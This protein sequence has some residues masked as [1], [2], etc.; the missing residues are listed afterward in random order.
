MVSGVIYNA[1]CQDCPTST[2]ANPNKYIGTSGKSLHARS[3]VHAKEIHGKSSSN[4]LYKHNLKFH[5]ESHQNYSRFK[6]NKVST[7]RSTLQRLLT[8]AHSISTSQE[9]LMNSK[10]EYGAAKWISLEAKK[11]YT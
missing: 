10:L 2:D 11:S 1:I 6:F 9:A 8:E 4:S 3:S 7:H 5:P